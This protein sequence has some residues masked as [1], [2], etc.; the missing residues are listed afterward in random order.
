VKLRFGAVFGLTTGMILLILLS[1]AVQ[2]LG[3]PISFLPAIDLLQAKFPSALAAP[4]EN[5]S[6]LTPTEYVFLPIINQAPEPQLWI[7][8]SDRQVSLDYFNQVYRASEGV[9]IEWTGNHASCD[10][11]ETAAAF[12]EAVRLRINYFRAMAGVPNNIQLSDEYNRKAQQAALMMSVNGQLSHNPP[13][14]WKCYSDEG[15]QAAG[16]SNL[17]LG[18]Y[19]STAITGFIRDSGSGNYAVG[20]RRWILYPQTEWMGTGDIPSTGSYWSSNALWVF[21]ENMSGPRPQTREEYVAWPPA[22]FVP[23]QVIFPRWSFAIDDANFSEATV[24]MSS[25]GQGIPLTL[26]PVVIGY[27]ENTLV[28]EPNLSFGTPP[29]SDTAFNV[30]VRGV[31]INGVLHE[32]AYQV[33]SFDPG[34]LAGMAIGMP[35]EQIDEDPVQPGNR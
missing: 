32:F 27:G 7:D 31:K 11:G 15:K 34:P 18:I 26:Q 12:R 3:Q 25:G 9:A 2:S 8:P 4:L 6:V 13:P 29:P 23:Y 22:G 20:H 35:S 24:E 5:S 17:Y 28:W 19:G 1:M 30:T 33:I 16:N 21:D 14:S 10:A